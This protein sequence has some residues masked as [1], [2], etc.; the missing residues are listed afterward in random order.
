VFGPDW[1]EGC[2]MCSSV[3]DGFDSLRIHLEHHD[4]A[5]T[6]VSRAPI[7]KLTA[8]K[9]RMAWSFPWA[10]AYRSDLNFDGVPAE[11]GPGHLAAAV[12]RRSGAE[13]RTAGRPRERLPTASLRKTP[14]VT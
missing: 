13:R 8:Y 9:Q 2:P 14:A 6:A 3:A 5:L 10:S 11:P 1:T 12:W 4:V 7:E